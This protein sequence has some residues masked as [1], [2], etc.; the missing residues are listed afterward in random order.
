MT[1]STYSCYRVL[2]VWLLAFFGGGGLSPYFCFFSFCPIFFV[3]LFVVFFSPEKNGY[4]LDG[5]KLGSVYR[6]VHLRVVEECWTSVAGHRQLFLCSSVLHTVCGCFSVLA[7][8]VEVLDSW[9]LQHLKYAWQ[10]FVLGLHFWSPYAKLVM[11][12]LSLSQI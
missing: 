10:N 4:Q 3:H 6:S 8:F 2:F 12:I 1:S 5:W 9:L 7:G 11:D